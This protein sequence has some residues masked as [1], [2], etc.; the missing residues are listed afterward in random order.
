M[1]KVWKENMEKVCFAAL[2]Y[3]G[4]ILV[5]LRKYNWHG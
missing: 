2:D 4:L 1:L 3:I 5:Q